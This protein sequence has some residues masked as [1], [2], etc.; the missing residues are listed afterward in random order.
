MGARAAL[1]SLTAAALLGLLAAPLLRPE[2]LQ[3]EERW[4]QWKHSPQSVVVELYTSQGCSSCPPADALLR[5]L[6][7]KAQQ[8]R[9][10][11]YPLS[12]HVDYWNFLGWDDPYSG[13][14]ATARQ[15]AYQRAL[16]RK[17]VYTPQVVVNGAAEVIGSQ[18]RA[19]FGAIDQ[20]FTQASG[21]EM[22]VVSWDSKTQSLEIS[23]KNLQ[24]QA[25]LGVAYVKPLAS[26]PV[27][28]GENAGSTLS[29][30]KVVRRFDSIAL[31]TGSEFTKKLELRS[32]TKEKLEVLL[33][34]QEEKGMRILAAMPVAN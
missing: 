29:H 2:L 27:V 32:F 5:E 23:V 22:E 33:L 3:A 10:R 21:V 17:N 14:T 4:E 24:Q 30:T 8:Q 20:A 34:L 6:S 11:L 25:V 19:V 1:Y 7:E 18:R 28:R 15:R 31:P 13:K 9:V 26:N 12:F 16:G